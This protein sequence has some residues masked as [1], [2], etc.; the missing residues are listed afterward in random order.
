MVRGLGAIALAM[1]FTTQ[2]ITAQDYDRS[3]LPIPN[4]QTPPIREM[5]ARKATKPA[6]LKLR[7]PKGLPM[8]SWC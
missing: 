4:P 8:W 6:P 5:D 7:L 2:A 3:S 1:L